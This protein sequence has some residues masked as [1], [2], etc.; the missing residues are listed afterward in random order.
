MI[1]LAVFDLD[2]TLVD[3]RRDLA[4]AA[5]ALVRELGGRA[6]ADQDIATMVGEGAAVLVRRVLSA[7]GLDT[8]TPGALARFLELY[9]ERLVEYTV[10]Y[11]GVRPT[12]THLAARMPLAVLTNKP[13]GATDRLLEILGLADYFADILGG[14]TAVGRKPDPAG[15]LTL[16]ARAGVPPAETVLIGDSTIDLETARRA[17]TQIVLA[18]YGFGLF[19]VSLNRGEQIVASPSEIPA[20]LSG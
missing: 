4:N 6:L 15:L 17:H 13:Q 20:A 2:G 7:A 14:D 9:D 16:C 3:S 1:R 5:N 8:A 12:L 11:E 19:P 10:S 18:S